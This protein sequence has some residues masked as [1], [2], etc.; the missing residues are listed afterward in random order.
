MSQAEPLARLQVG[1]VAER[2]KAASAWAV[3]VWR[4][5]AVLPGAP[6]VA[7]W[8]AL[9]G[10]AECMNFYVGPADVELHRTDAAGY[11]DNLSTGTPLLWV[12]LRATG[13]EPPYRVITVT[14][15]PGEGEAFTESG[16]DLVDAVPMPEP[17]RAAIAQF[18][19]QHYVEHQFIKR[20]RDRFDQK[21]AVRRSPLK[22]H[23]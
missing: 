19:A 20:Q 18:I 6:D 15:A 1:V 14:A 5:V 17:M 2:R 11:R 3:Y 16:T 4:P 9:D 7:Q 21:T 10:N 8:T 13:G 12:V 22:D 23:K